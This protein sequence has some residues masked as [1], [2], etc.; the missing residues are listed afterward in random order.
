MPTIDMKLS[1]ALTVVKRS[2]EMKNLEN[3]LA[4]LESIIE[5]QKE[6]E[7]KEESK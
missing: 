7:K 4:I 6:I 5:Q 1:E 3:A 2:I